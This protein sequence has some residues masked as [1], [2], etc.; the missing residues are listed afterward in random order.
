MER[1]KTQ[2]KK[3]EKKN[4]KTKIVKK[5]FNLGEEKEQT[6]QKEEQIKNLEKLT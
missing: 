4:N 5:H 2:K 3:E 1:T 6:E